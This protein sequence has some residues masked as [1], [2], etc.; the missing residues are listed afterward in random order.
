[1]K[2]KLLLILGFMLLVQGCASTRMVESTD[3]GPR[4]IAPG[5][6][7]IVFLRSSFVGSAI[8]ASIFDATGD[9]RFI[10][11]LSN[12]KK[13]SHMVEPGEYTFM[14]VS[15]AADFM[16][17][18]LDAGKTYYAVITPRMGAWKARFSMKPVRNGGTGDFQVGSSEF[19]QW[20]SENEFTEN[21][22][23]SRA[24]FEEN[25]ASVEEK[26]ADYWEVWLTKPEA[27]K[28]ERTLNAED[29]V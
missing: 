11:I 7:Q 4:E 23:E 17:A 20:L 12:G 18:T 5:K 24:W 2:T 21:T 16:P 9:T 19:R 22:P 13:I 1:M 28:A 29:G 27:D 26:R 15:E 10:G 6:A 14:V 25:Q 8:Q 3:Q